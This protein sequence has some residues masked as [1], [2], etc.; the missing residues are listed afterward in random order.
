MGEKILLCVCQTAVAVKTG[1]F[2]FLL[3]QGFEQA[4]NLN[5]TRRKNFAKFDFQ[6][7]QTKNWNFKKILKI[8]Y[9][10][11]CRNKNILFLNWFEDHPAWK[12]I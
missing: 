9:W 7:V 2:F 6:R 11:N 12:I 5:L 8:F 10:Q 4:E 3:G 1:Q